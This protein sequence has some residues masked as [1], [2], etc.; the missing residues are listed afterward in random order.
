MHLTIRGRHVAISP[1]L[2]EHCTERVERALLPFAQHVDSAEVVLADLNGPRGGLGQ[3]C[4][5]TVG[6]SDGTK[7]MVQSLDS[8]FYA[9]SGEAAGRVG[10]LVRRELGRTRTRARRAP[11]PRE[12]A[13]IRAALG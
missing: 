1:A 7:L 8:D 3:A 13:E 11:R 4:R 6:L 5:L 12:Q 10:H 2:R 9:A